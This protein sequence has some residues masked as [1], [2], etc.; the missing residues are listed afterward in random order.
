MFNF[1]KTL[2]DEALRL[3][4]VAASTLPM[5]LIA[6]YILDILI[7]TLGGEISD[8]VLTQAAFWMWASM[9]ILGMVPGSMKES[10]GRV[11]LL[12]VWF[13]LLVPMPAYL[14]ALGGD[15]PGMIG[16]VWICFYLYL[17]FGVMVVFGGIA[18]YLYFTKPEVFFHALAPASQASSADTPQDPSSPT[19]G[20]AT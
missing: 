9:V 20:A 4:A 6:T 1:G 17:I 10:M 15:P 16:S 5:A 7:G 14:S 13:G 11:C 18:G 12:V 8:G 2:S 19:D 3:L